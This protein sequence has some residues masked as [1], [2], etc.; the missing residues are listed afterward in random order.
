WYACK[1]CLDLVP[2]W[3]NIPCYHHDGND[4]TL[5]TPSTAIMFNTLTDSSVLVYPSCQ[6]PGCADA[7]TLAS[8]LPRNS[9]PESGGRAPRIL[10]WPLADTDREFSAN[11][12]RQA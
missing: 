1:W 5:Y 4:I 6:C 2:G 10:G 8:E 3:V 11:F 7:R 9:D 12:D